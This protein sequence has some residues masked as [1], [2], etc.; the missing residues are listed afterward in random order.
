MEPLFCCPVMLQSLTYGVSVFLEFVATPR[1]ASAIKA[2][3]KGFATPAK[4]D[5][6]PPLRTTGPRPKCV[7]LRRT[8]AKWS[9]DSRRH[10]RG[11]ALARSHEVTPNDGVGAAPAGCGARAFS[12]PPLSAAPCPHGQARLGEP[13]CADH[14]SGQ[15]GAHT[16][17]ANRGQRPATPCFIAQR[18]GNCV[19]AAGLGVQTSAETADVTRPPTA[20]LCRQ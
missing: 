5:Q 8:Q 6:R 19:L 7:D 3:G 13:V 4:S 12:P 16:P 15:R 17:A 18:R 1:K 20:G 11:Q 9:A 10:D 2:V 14:P